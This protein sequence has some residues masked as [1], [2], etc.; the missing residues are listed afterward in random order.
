MD[1]CPGGKLIAF[2]LNLKAKYTLGFGD[3]SIVLIFL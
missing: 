3:R 2:L 1:I